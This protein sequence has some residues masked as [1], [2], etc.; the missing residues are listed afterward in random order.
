TGD[1][2]RGSLMLALAAVVATD[3]PVE[4][5]IALTALASAAGTAER[6]AAMAMLPRMVGESRLAPANALLHTVQDLGVVV[7]PSIGAVLLAI[8]PDAVAF[9]VNG[10]TFAASAT[11]IS[12]M[13]RRAAPSGMR[14]VEGMRA[15]LMHGLQT[16]RTT[17]FVV[18]LFAVV[19]MAELTYGAQTVQLVLYAASSLDAGTAGYGYLLAVAGLGG[20]LSAA[21]NARLAA[22]TKVAGIVVVAGAVFCATQLA[23]AWTSATAIALLVTLL[24]G[25]GFVACEVVAETA[26]ARVVRSEV[27]GR[28]MGVFEA[29]SVAA[30][31][32]G[33][34]LAPVLISQTSLRTSFVVLGILT[35]VVTFACLAG[36]RRLGE[37]SKRRADLLASRLEVI[38][39][40]PILI[41]APRIVLEQL[42]SA[43]QICP[44]P[45]GVDVV[46]EGAPA[47]AF[48]A[49]VDGTVLVHLNGEE[50]ARI[51][52]GGSFGERGLLDNAPRN[53]TVTTETPSTVIRIEGDVLLDA[54]QAAPTVLSAIDRSNNVRAAAPVSDEPGSIVD[55]PAWEKA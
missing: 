35:V 44:L 32:L 24:G 37:L 26:L 28:V 6:P 36:L 48:Y 15:E 16:A 39:Q 30:M 17:P 55:D 34:V 42:A 19:A 12:T 11:L 21:F 29:L 7:G 40:L 25:A 14:Q 1:L 8:A 2:L 20:L 31:V 52:P 22:S 43:S 45:P 27:L 10:A 5:V 46:A 41:G 50:I 54:L 9:L 13:Q 4:L 51:G 18:P 49:V 3:A 38:E 47:H 53:A 23:Y 33:A